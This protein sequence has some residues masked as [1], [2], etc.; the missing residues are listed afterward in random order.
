M[1]FVR[2]LRVGMLAVVVASALLAAPWATAGTRDFTDGTYHS[3]D[4]N[5]DQLDPIQVDFDL[6]DGL[7]TNYGWLWSA[8]CT[9]QD[10]VGVP[11]GF[12][13][14]G[15][16]APIPVTAGHFSV[17]DERNGHLEI[18]GDVTKDGTASGTAS[19]ENEECSSGVQRWTAADG[20]QTVACHVESEGRERA[21]KP[22]NF[23]V[24]VGEGEQCTGKVTAAVVQIGAKKLK[25]HGKLPKVNAFG[26]PQKITLHL[27]RATQR[28]IALAKK[29][30]ESSARVILE[31][32][33]EDSWGPFTGTSVVEIRERRV[34]QDPD[35]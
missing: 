35:G 33:L 21:D 5:P 9:F 25:Y 20:G 18:E 24:S 7:I 3:D 30:G 6:K 1:R 15:Q 19:W 4:G 14:D 17:D 13:A 34:Q 22:I 29:V 10:E 23:T 27:D 26:T 16:T 11:Y 28:K 32:Q 12:F 31:Y 8:T 2:A